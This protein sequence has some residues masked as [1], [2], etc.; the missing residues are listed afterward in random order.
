MNAAIQR[1]QALQLAPAWDTVEHRGTW[2]HL[3][4]RD[5]GSPE[6]PRLLV[7]VVTS[8]AATRDDLE[9]V[10]SALA[11][12][13]GLTGLL[14]VVTDSLAEV[15]RGELREVLW[16]EADLCFDLAGL[17]LRLP[18]DAFFQVNT[19]GAEILVQTVAEALGLTAGR[20]GGTLLDLYCGVGTFGLALAQGYD[21]VVGIELHAPAIDDAR[22]NA[23]ANGIAGSWHAGLV[24]DVLPG[25]PDSGARAIL[26]DPPRVGLHPRAAR[27]LA[28]QPGDVLVYVAC[29]PASLGRDR[30]VLEAGGWRLTDLWTVDLFP[31]THHIEAVARFQRD[32]ATA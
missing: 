30:A 27:F 14:W 4:L 16:G 18:Y 7:S 32:P 12:L 31:Q 20:P 22:Q 21:Q 10:V 9:P 5:S 17:S 11:D 8:S 23:A 6:A 1:V 28:D 15:A 2:R 26:V 29:G 19:Q 24:E 25:L 13:P 3:V